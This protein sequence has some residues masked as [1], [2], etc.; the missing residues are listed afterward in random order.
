MTNSTSIIALISLSLSTQAPSSTNTP[1]TDANNE[2][3][4]LSTTRMSYINYI[5]STA[6][7]NGWLPAQTDATVTLGT[8]HMLP[9]T[10]Y[11]TIVSL[12]SSS[13]DSMMDDTI[14]ITSTA[15]TNGWLT[16]Q[17]DATVTLGT[18]HMYYTS[19]S[20]V[21]SPFSSSHDNMMDDTIYITSTANTNGWLP[22]QTDAT[23]TLG[24]THMY[25]TSY[26]TVVSLF[27]SSHDHMMD[28]TI[29]IT[30]T[31]N[32]NGWLPSQKLTVTVA[33]TSI[34]NSGISKQ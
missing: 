6:N 29:Y 4:T 30:S 10:S 21:V 3:V 24:T 15:N 22:A 13:H 23:V 25:H 34:I 19:Y 8:T 31:A 32:T 7:T 18:T 14:Y 9:H 16:A 27:S 12:F 1:S 17:T 5:T 26:S 33:V 28:D 2:I 20:T 11:S